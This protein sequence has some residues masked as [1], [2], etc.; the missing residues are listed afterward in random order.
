[1]AIASYRY[2]EIEE[3]IVEFLSDFGRVSYPFDIFSVL[4]SGSS[5]ILICP[6]R[7]VGR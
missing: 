7:I 1:M 4:A 6:S 2:R 5:R 3:T